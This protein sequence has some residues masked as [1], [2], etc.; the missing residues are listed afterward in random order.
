MN[1]APQYNLVRFLFSYSSRS[2]T[3]GLRRPSPLTCTVG[4]VAVWA[5]NAAVVASQR[6]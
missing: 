4:H 5:V 1:K 3:S 6:Q 2:V